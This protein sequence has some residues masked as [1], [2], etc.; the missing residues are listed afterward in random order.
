M[1]VTGIIAEYNPFHNGHKYQ[2]DYIKN[3]TSAD[4]VIVA[5][6]SDYVQRGTPAIFSKH[7]RAKMAL[8]NGADLVIELPVSVS[9]SS[10]EFFCS[11]GVSLLDRLGVVDTL[12][13]G[14]EIG[15]LT[16]IKKIAAI[17]SEEPDKYR[18]LLKKYLSNGLPFPQAR[19]HALTEYCNLPYLEK[20]LN[21]P[22]NILAIEYCKALI[23][24]HSSIN[25][26]TIKRKGMGYN[27]TLSDLSLSSPTD[28]PASA[29]AIREIIYKPNALCNL[30]IL[31]SFMPKNICT[32]AKSILNNHAYATPGMFDQ[33]LIY[34][35]MKSDLSDLTKYLDVSHELARRIIN[36]RNNITGFN[37]AVTLLKT[38]E[39]TQTRIQRA[40]LHI[41]LG[42]QDVPTQMPYARVLGFKK[43]SSAL[44][45]SIKQNASIPLITKLASAQN[46]L[47]QKEKQ[48]LDETVF[49]S[50]LYE[51]L[52]SVNFGQ[53]FVH[54][55]QKR[56]III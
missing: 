43:E 55:F 19:S 7:T 12:C 20:I 33:I 40:L 39:L 44:L 54:E 21:S 35:L 2:I 24:Q 32:L 13:F 42:I 22:N 3:K 14:S 26:V 4:Y 5:M 49:S 37:Q 1:K 6:S 38:K 56:I 53:P 51:K 30:N 23:Q 8:L 31:D 25:P 46:I 45:K 47:S 52:I 15:E 27:D 9:T 18:A 48:L 34:A 17:L 16:I 11:G 50:N 41:I 36:T 10:A 29:S 28:E